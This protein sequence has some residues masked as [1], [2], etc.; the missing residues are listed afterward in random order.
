MN[1]GSVTIV[2]GNSVWTDEEGAEVR[3]SKS[4]MEVVES[5]DP[6][7][8][9]LLGVVVGVVVLVALKDVDTGALVGA[10]V[11]RPILVPETVGVERVWIIDPLTVSGWFKNI[12]HSCANVGISKLPSSAA[13]LQV[14]C[15][16]LNV[17][18]ALVGS[19][20]NLHTQLAS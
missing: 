7:D 17:S 20:T 11:G 10:N 18:F 4:G 14:F 2:V 5:V 13:V 6:V 1:L 19:N 8:R 12:L 16:Q 3:V 15:M 9:K